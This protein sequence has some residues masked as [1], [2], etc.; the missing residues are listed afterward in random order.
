M[1]MIFRFLNSVFKATWKIQQRIVSYAAKRNTSTKLQKT[2]YIVEVFSNILFI[3]LLALAVLT[4]LYIIYSILPIVVLIYLICPFLKSIETP[5]ISIR[6]FIKNGIL[7][8]LIMGFVIL[9]ILFTFFESLNFSTTTQLIAINI[10]FSVLW[11]FYSLLANNKMSKLINT[12]N[13]AFFSIFTLV[14]NLILNSLPNNL[15]CYN[16]FNDIKIPEGYS[17]KQILSL[18]VSLLL[19]FPLITNATAAALCAVKGYWIEKY[20]NGNDISEEMIIQEIEKIKPD[21][22]VS[23]E[24]KV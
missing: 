22:I 2:I 23:E 6:G 20:N 15:N 3:V 18:L 19:I 4:K 11:F 12:C 7:M 8:I 16:L 10:T 14:I 17:Q 24:I 13:A 9:T 21:A 1:G 5:F